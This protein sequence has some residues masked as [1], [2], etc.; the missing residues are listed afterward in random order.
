MSKFES[1]LAV[2]EFRKQ[3]K[4][5]FPESTPHF[6]CG[7]SGGV[8]SMCLLYLLHRFGLHATVVHINYG[9]RGRESDKD[10]ELVEQMAN[11][12]R[13]ESVS[14]KFEPG[15]RDQNNFQAWAR[16]VRY[17]VFRDLMDET[18][19]DYI[20]TAHHRD[21]QV[22]TILQKIFRGAGLSNWKGMNVLDGDLFRPLLEVPKDE[23][24]E[25]AK[26]NEIPFR[27]DQSNLEATYARNV[28]RLKLAPELDTFFPGWSDNIL[29]I[30]QRAEEA[31][32]LTGEILRRV[33]EGEGILNREKYLELDSGIRPVILAEFIRRS[34]QDGRISG[35]IKEIAVDL[36]KLE[37]GGELSLPEGLQLVRD[38][39]RIVLKHPGRET[40]K[41]VITIYST[42]QL[43]FQLDGGKISVDKWDGNFSRQELVSDL[44]AISFPLKIRRWCDGDRIIPLG[45]NGSKLVSDLLTDHKIS[46]VQKR[47]AKVVESF[48]G[49]LCA[50]IFPHITANGLPGVIADPVKCTD[51]TKQVLKL[52][53]IT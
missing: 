48:D 42:D 50:V 7:A 46:S 3:L 40:E 18:G 15:E 2:R 4:N 49:N 47:D 39:E 24:T 13:F 52:S 16:D 51:Q 10:Q 25:F 30:S 5:C 36:V 29:K 14:A 38:R 19:A 45:M 8:D 44:K 35:G 41:Q 11:L 9:M 20:I 21:D 28:I 37:S 33:S 27:E 26:A 1:A 17:R 6:I 53:N 34:V 12:W 32:R 43:P 23:I 31:E 22:E